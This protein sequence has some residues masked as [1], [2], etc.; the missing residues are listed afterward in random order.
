LFGAVGMILLVVSLFI[1]VGA[2]AFWNLGIHLP[3][4][5]LITLVSIFSL[6]GIQLIVAGLLAD[7]LS[8]I[9]AI[10]VGTKKRG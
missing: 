6:S 7:R 2:I 5:L 3:K 8:R 4:L 1:T 9:H 10:P